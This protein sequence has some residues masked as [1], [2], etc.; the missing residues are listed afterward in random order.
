MELH[1]I[2]S[3]GKIYEFNVVKNSTEPCPE[4]GVPAC[5]KE[6]ILWFEEDNKR[7]AIL[8]TEASLT[9]LEKSFLIKI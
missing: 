1:E 7:K 8:L 9:L 4:C 2:E 5:G 6:D 3:D